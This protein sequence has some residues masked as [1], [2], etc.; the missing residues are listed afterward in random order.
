MIITCVLGGCFILYSWRRDY[1]D[2]MT[3]CVHSCK[4]YNG[5]CVAKFVYSFGGGSQK[6]VVK[7]SIMGSSF[8]NLNE[9]NSIVKYIANR[10][11]V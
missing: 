10:F 1:V 7:V 2:G 5:R 9:T 6:I 11:G 8:R 3:L 4:T